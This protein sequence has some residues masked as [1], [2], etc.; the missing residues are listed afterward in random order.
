MTQQE[1]GDWLQV[2][3]PDTVVLWVYS[4][5]IRDSQ[6]AVSKVLVRS[7]PGIN[8]RDVGQLAKG[9]KV[10]IKGASASGEWLKIAPPA[11]CALWISRKYVEPAV[12]RPATEPSV[13]SA[14]LAVAAPASKKMPSLSA[15]RKDNS[16]PDMEIA[17]RN[18]KIPAALKVEML[19]EEKEQGKGV[20]YEGVLGSAGLVWRK[21]SKFRL[22][23]T[24]AKG[25]IVAACYILG[26]ESYLASLKGKTLL[27]YGREYWVQGVQYP[28]VAADQIVP[29]E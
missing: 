20:Q 7:G 21:P 10:A 4:E 25:H 14:G 15:G 11:G 18:M 17:T 24:D 19:V 2:A 29:R 16:A 28:V 8:Y 27:V 23:K 22:I 5:L 26:D 1:E 3:P 6:A 13:S 12:S 9:D